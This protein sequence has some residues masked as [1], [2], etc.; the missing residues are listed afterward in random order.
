[1]KSALTPRAKI[2]RKNMTEAE[3]VLW[4]NLR[5]NQLAVKFRK[6]QPLGNY[7]LDFVCFERRLV[8][9]VD[10]GQHAGSDYD[11]KRDAYLASQGFEVMRFWNHDV[12]THTEAVLKMIRGKV[13]PS[14]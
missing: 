13:L 10:G 2:L 1:M 7:I 12:L 3:K 9:E 6:Q 8:V 14:P 11:M 5:N 4:H